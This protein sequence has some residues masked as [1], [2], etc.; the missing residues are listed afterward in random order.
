MTKEAPL[1]PLLDWGRCRYVI[2][3]EESYFRRRRRPRVEEK[4]RIPSGTLLISSSDGVTLCWTPSLPA[5]EKTAES[6]VILC[7]DTSIQLV[8]KENHLVISLLCNYLHPER[9]PAK[10]V[11]DEDFSGSDSS[12]E[13]L[14]M[15]TTPESSDDILKSGF[16]ASFRQM[17]TILL[18]ISLIRILDDETD[19]GHE[20]TSSPL[21]QACLKRQLVGCRGVF[22]DSC[23]ATEISVPFQGS[24]VRF[25]V[26]S[27][28]PTPSK[29]KSR[30]QSTVR[31]GNEK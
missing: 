25:R 20:S 15:Q 24:T 30:H 11:H 17:P 29:S 5:A 7:Y 13:H 19:D 18:S 8:G 10:S 2:R 6:S 1:L 9:Y 3:D 14:C 12:H 16:V 22:L 26:I 27:I 23:V 28:I 21:E 31:H 4:R